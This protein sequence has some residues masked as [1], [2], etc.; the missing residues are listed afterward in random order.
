MTTSFSMPEWDSEADDDSNSS[1]EFMYVK[2]RHQNN[3][4]S[5]TNCDGNPDEIS[6]NIWTHQDRIPV[7]LNN[8]EYLF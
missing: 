8:G 7:N 2:G 5:S 3:D 1:E 6:S 4:I